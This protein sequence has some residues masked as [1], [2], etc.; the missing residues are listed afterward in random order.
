M[1]S[2]PSGVRVILAG[3]HQ[4]ISGFSDNRKHSLCVKAQRWKQYCSSPCG[5]K[6]VAGGW[7][8]YVLVLGRFLIATKLEPISWSAETLLPC[9]TKMTFGFQETQIPALPISALNKWCR[10]LSLSFCPGWVLGC[11]YTHMASGDTFLC[12]ELLETNE[13]DSVSVWMNEP[14][15]TGFQL[16]VLL[17]RTWWPLKSNSFHFKFCHPMHLTFKMIRAASG[18]NEGCM[19][20]SRKNYVILIF[21]SWQPCWCAVKYKGFKAWFT[22]KH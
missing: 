18:I 9:K 22:I 3:C 5:F 16:E 11:R 17:L 12:L 4:G 19:R 7:C 10:I 6:Y 13:P 15:L 14:W 20:T 1:P 21:C 2:P 8:L